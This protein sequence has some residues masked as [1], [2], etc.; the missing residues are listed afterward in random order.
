MATDTTEQIVRESPEVEAYKLNLMKAAGALQPPTL[1]GYQVAGLT[2]QQTAALQAGQ[3]GIGAYT[4]YMQ[5]GQAALTA[6]T[7]TTG[8][9]ANLLRGA[10]TRGQFAA[11]QQAYNQAAVPASQIGQLSNVAG[12]GIGNIAAGVSDID[13]AHGSAVS[14]S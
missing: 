8:E 5:A 6:G 12:A 9:A 11:A 10:D 4:P 2:P 14:N 3:Q 13:P 1:P 7:A